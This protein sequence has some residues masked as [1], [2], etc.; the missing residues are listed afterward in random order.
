[1][2]KRTIFP[3][4]AEISLLDFSKV[5]T[6]EGS[7]LNF[8]NVINSALDSFQSKDEGARGSWPESGVD[9]NLVL[10]GRGAM[11]GPALAAG[12]YVGRGFLAADHMV[13]LHIYGTAAAQMV[14]L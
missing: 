11:F 8:F 12:S 7:E 6:Y 14:L 9:S 5:V 3:Q 1:M 2:P 4:G 10:L 13:L